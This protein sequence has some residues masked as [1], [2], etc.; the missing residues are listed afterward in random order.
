M[1]R[2][3]YIC[4]GSERCG[5]EGCR[6]RKPHSFYMDACDV[7]RCDT[8]TELYGKKESDGRK[9]VI[10]KPAIVEANEILNKGEKKD[11]EVNKVEVC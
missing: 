10:Y 3:R 6:H 2:Q 11:G 1:D 4:T 7:P 8:L 5:A 9:C